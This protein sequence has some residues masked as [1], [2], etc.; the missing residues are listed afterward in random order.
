MAAVAA[1]ET[2]VKI[3]I[4]VDGDTSET[5]CRILAVLA[6]PKKVAKFR[7]WARGVGGLALPLRGLRCHL[8]TLRMPKRLG[9]V[10]VD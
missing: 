7:R 4:I 2:A 3:I 5:G 10:K 8:K 9:M 1:E 6:E